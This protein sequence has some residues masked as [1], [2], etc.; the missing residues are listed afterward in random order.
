[1]E[2]RKKIKKDLCGLK[3]SKSLSISKM[4][5]SSKQPRQGRNLQSS[6]AFNLKA[7]KVLEA[8]RMIN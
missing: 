1:M 6:S 8:G 2:S 5:K 4:T 7:V 3:A